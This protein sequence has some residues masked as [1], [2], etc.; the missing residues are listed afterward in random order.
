MKISELGFTEYYHQFIVFEAD[1]LTE[2]LKEEISIG[3][4]DCFVL[5]SNHIQ[6]NGEL[7]FDVLSVGS[8]WE[9]YRKGLRR[10]KMLGTYAVWE[11]FDLEMQL[12][13]PDASMIKKFRPYQMEEEAWA[14]S[15]LWFTRYDDR[16]DMVRDI[17]YPDCVQ[18]GLLTN[19]GIEE[20]AMEMT[21]FNGPF[22]EGE[23]LEKPHPSLHLQ[24]GDILRT[25]PYQ[26]GDHYSLLAV[27]AGNHLSK[28]E[29]EAMKE[30]IRSGDAEGFGFSFPTLKN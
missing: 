10:K 22:L 20:Y 30:L 17:V 15:E 21:G 1:T 6:E 23:L 7:V 16:L 11:V 8:S 18:A 4:K 14:D 5:C 26:L 13:E 12:V 9:T 27:F 24:P 2:K 28:E 25:L 29:E 3:D 19:R